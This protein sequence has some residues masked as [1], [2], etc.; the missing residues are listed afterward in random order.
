M[1][2]RAKTS[3]DIPLPLEKSAIA[4]Q[5]II[6]DLD[7]PSFFSVHPEENQEAESSEM[8]KT[9]KKIKSKPVVIPFPSSLE[10]LFENADIEFSPDNLRLLNKI[11]L[12]DL[13][14][15]VLVELPARKLKKDECFRVQ[16]EYQQQGRILEIDSENNVF[17]VFK[18]IQAQVIPD[19]P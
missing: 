5:K 16:P 13:I 8:V 7:P 19:P 10:K 17:W 3:F 18:K 12:R 14:T 15:A 1:R 2:K 11:D 9:P 6:P 4:D